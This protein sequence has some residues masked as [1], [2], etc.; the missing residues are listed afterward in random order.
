MFV[1]S[2]YSVAFG[3]PGEYSFCGIPVKVIDNDV[4][5]CSKWIIGVLAGRYINTFIHEMGHNLAYRYA[6]GKFGKISINSASGGSCEISIEKWRLDKTTNLQNFFIIISGNLLQASFGLAT[7]IATRNLH[8][9]SFNYSNRISYALMIGVLKARNLFSV[10][11]SLREPV[12]F[13]LDLRSG[14]RSQ[15][16][17][18]KMYRDFGCVGVVVSSAL[19]LGI[20]SLA[21]PMILDFPK[22]K[23]EPPTIIEKVNDFFTFFLARLQ[24]SR[25]ASWLQYETI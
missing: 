23:K 16:D 24:P 25:T 22:K 4:S 9:S 19:I 8:K 12:N 14:V 10:Y 3:I 1:E 15:S 2:L 5:L 21:I 7:S 18:M 17:F 13:L 11:Q 20:G 6:Y